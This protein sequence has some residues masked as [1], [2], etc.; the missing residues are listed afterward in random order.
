MKKFIFKASFFIAPFLFLY[1]ITVLFY[2]DAESPD[3]IR[4]GCFPNV[5]KEYRGVFHDEFNRKIY[6]NKYSERKNRN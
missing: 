4:L 3:L 1:A 6:F 2:S 5:F